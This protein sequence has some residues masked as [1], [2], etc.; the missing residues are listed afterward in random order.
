MPYWRRLSLNSER[1][2]PFH[3]VD[4]SKALARK[5]LADRETHFYHVLTDTIIT[6]CVERGVGTLA[7]SWP[8]DVRESDW[9][10]TGNKKL[11]KWAFDRIY[12]YLEY[13]GE[14]RGVEV[15][16]ENEW[17][18]SKTCSRCGDDTKSNRVER[19]LYVCLS[20]EMVANA[21]CNGAENMRQKIT[22]SPHGE[23][24]SNGC[25]VVRET[26]SL[27]ITK[28]EDFRTTQPSVH[29][30]DRESGTFTTREQVVS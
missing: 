11:H 5:K 8:E 13:K 27:V 18:T 24:R 16:K 26:T 17:N 19:G 14:I 7:V 28:I 9:G 23:D 2:P 10:K 29:L 3:G 20:C 30:F 4:E 15:L 6:E 12:Q 25:V 1:I 22:P 21:D